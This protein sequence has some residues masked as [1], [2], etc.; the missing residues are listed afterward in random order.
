M[1]LAPTSGAASEDLALMYPTA[2][3]ELVKWIGCRFNFITD[4]V[5]EQVQAQV[6]TQKSAA[7]CLI[8]QQELFGKI[9]KAHGDPIAFKNKIDSIILKKT[10]QLQAGGIPSN[11][12]VEWAK[13]LTRN[14]KFPELKLGIDEAL[15]EAYPT[16]KKEENSVAEYLRNTAG[17]AEVSHGLS[18]IKDGFKS[19]I[20]QKYKSHG[21]K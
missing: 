5:K 20:E 13:C 15:S 9:T 3:Q 19:L 18:M 6:L 2:Q 17:S 1:A 4:H 14:I 10:I 16:C 7:I 12:S 11:P 8:Q 21:I